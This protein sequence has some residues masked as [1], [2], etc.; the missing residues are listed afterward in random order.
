MLYLFFLINNEETIFLMSLLPLTKFCTTFCKLIF[1]S[2]DANWPDIF[3]KARTF[4][5][6]LFRIAAVL[7]IGVDRW[8][9]HVCIIKY[10]FILNG[11]NLS[12]WF[13]NIRTLF[14]QKHWNLNEK[15]NKENVF[16]VKC[17]FKKFK[18]K[19]LAFSC[20]IA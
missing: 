9:V 18:M 1:S 13:I 11:I 4:L 5:F 12:I 15:I 19:R 7:K 6:L 3:F 8:S 17:F 16:L 20:D 14:Y 2:L 10:K